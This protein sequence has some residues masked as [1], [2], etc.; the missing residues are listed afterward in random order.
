MDFGLGQGTTDSEDHALAIG[1]A[2][3]VGDVGGT[4]FDR[5][6]DTKIVVGGVERHVGDF[7]ERMDAPLPKF[8]VEL[9]VGFENLETVDFHP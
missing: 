2:H 6:V 3:A 8:F 1:T 4:V 7:G 5:T 9:L